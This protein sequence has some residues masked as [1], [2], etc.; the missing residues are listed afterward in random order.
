MPRPTTTPSAALDRDRCRVY[1]LVQ[2][3]GN[4]RLRFTV[5]DLRR[6]MMEEPRFRLADT[7]TLGRHFA[8]LNPATVT[9][10]GQPLVALEGELPEGG[11]SRGHHLYVLTSRL[12]E[13]LASP[14]HLPDAV[15]VHT[16]LWVAFDAVG[17]APV[18]TN[19]V[20]RVCRTIEPLAID[21]RIQMTTRLAAL[22]TRS[23]PLA[24]QVRAEQELERSRW[25]RWRP[26]GRRPENPRFDDW[27]AIMRALEDGMATPRRVGHVT[28]HEIA[29]E[30]V[31]LAINETRSSFWPY[32]RSVT[33]E[34]ISATSVDNSRAQE[35]LGLLRQRGT[36]L[37]KV[38]GDASKVR[39][40]GRRRAEPRVVKVGTV[41]GGRP[42]YDV[43]V[44]AG[45]EARS[46]AVALGDARAAAG[47]E[48]LAELDQEFKAAQRLARDAAHA[49]VAA[50]AAVRI[51][52]VH[53]ALDARERVVQ[54][55]MDQRHL[56]SQRATQTVLRLEGR[57]ADARR[58]LGGEVEE[59]REEAAERCNQVGIELS[60]VLG[61]AR[62]LL[63]GDKY[64]A[65]IPRDRRN[66]RTGPQLLADA[67]MLRRYPNPEHTHRS[68]RDPRRAAVTGVDRVE[69]LVHLAEKQG[70][71]TLTFVQG[72]ADLLGRDLRDP[73]L[74][75]VAL[76][77]SLHADGTVCDE[78][79]WSRALAALA[80][81]GDEAAEHES[82]SVMAG[83]GR[84][85]EQAVRAIYALCV[86]RRAGLARLPEWVC[87]SSH[88]S[89]VT[90]LRAVLR[91]ERSENW[92]L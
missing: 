18:D 38:L 92:L 12:P 58:R 1:D 46:L 64:L 59:A 87:S 9:S 31:G 43:P 51:Y 56:L 33:V 77:S 60:H 73:K 23:R 66:G 10:V 17:G 30:L 27:V 61:A 81:L 24:E 54:S 11:G 40:A 26:I 16:A 88:A 42:Y 90:V 44:R 82:L 67:T 63:I 39:I 29:V 86:M 48:A 50:V 3:V 52:L 53:R 68:E 28:V 32:G 7:R 4:E 45:L 74:V 79:L 55:L 57:L 13:H 8:A 34:D 14:P 22:A 36:S 2:R 80:L 41:D 5:A 47:H 83:A 25:R 71:R 75:R 62:P 15:R 84:S 91:A 6:T 19:T 35:L 89:I 70:A 72:A 69:A 78:R 20:T 65:W 85:P 37:G 49:A 21:D 76:A